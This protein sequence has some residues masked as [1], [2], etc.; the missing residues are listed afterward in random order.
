[1][2]IGRLQAADLFALSVLSVVSQSAGLF[3]ELLARPPTP[4]TFVIVLM[5]RHGGRLVDLRRFVDTNRG[6]CCSVPPFISAAVDRQPQQKSRNSAITGC[7]RRAVALRGALSAAQ[8]LLPGS[9]ASRLLPGLRPLAKALK[10]KIVS[11]C[12]ESLTSARGPG[13]RPQGSR[14]PPPKWWPPMVALC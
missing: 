5:F 3:H 4:V 13:R 8:Q 6:R 2:A 7:F 11:L 14:P 12:S 1:M 10:K 9:E